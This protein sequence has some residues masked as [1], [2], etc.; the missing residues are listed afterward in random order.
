MNITSHIAKHF[1]DVHFGGNWTWSN[2]KEQLSDVTWQEAITR[3]ENLN[4]IA[5]L[6]FHINYFIEAQIQVL[7]GGPLDAKD[8][9]SFAHPPINSQEDWDNFLYKIW[10]DA[11]ELKMLIE[12]LP[13]S[14]LNETF[15]ESKY[16]T[17]YRNLTGMIEH[18]H[19][20]LGQ[21]AVIKKLVRIQNSK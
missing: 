18:T 9:L 10:R 2:M 5:T 14:V 4:T 16:G 7:K 3:I 1:H 17:F 20:H 13:D 11:E 15:V 6:A 12:R 21:I 8:E 19:Y